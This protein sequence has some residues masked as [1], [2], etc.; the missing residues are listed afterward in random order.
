MVWKKGRG[1]RSYNTEKHKQKSK[2]VSLSAGIRELG[3]RVV[4][5]QRNEVFQRKECGGLQQ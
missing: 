1:I 5:Q 3:V 2:E 4:Q